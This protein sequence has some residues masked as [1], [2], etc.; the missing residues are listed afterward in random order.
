MQKIAILFLFITFT[1]SSGIA[2][3]SKKTTEEANPVYLSYCSNFG[4][5]VSYS[6]QSCVNNN[7]FLISTSIGGFYQHCTN[8]G[9][10]VDYFF[11]SCV[12]NSFREAQYRL[13][14]TIYLRDCQNYN[15]QTLDYFFVSCVNNNF[16]DIQRA[17]LR[18][19]DSN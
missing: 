3:E 7:F 4:N 8:F 17:I 14:N 18:Q 2:Q 16:S 12:N 10:E 1:L 5:G 13:K 11:L 15:R 6:Y 9:N 19:V